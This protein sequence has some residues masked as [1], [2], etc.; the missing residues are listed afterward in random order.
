MQVRVDLSLYPL[1]GEFIPPIKAFIERL[2]KVSGLTIEV[3]RMSTQV[4][5]EIS[6][7]FNSIEAAARETFAAPHRSALVMKML[8]GAQP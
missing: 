6:L 1:D 2:Q 5:G 3:N 4:D 7:V 8:G